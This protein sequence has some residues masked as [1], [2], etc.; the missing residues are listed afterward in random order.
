LKEKEMKRLALVLCLAAALPLAAC[1][2]TGTTSPVTGGPV[3][4]LPGAAPVCAALKS[5]KFDLVLKAYGAVTD[6]VNMAIDLKAITPGSAK[7]VA[8]ANANDKVLAALAVAEQA[9]SA[10]NATSYTAALANV[11]A[12]IAEVRTALRQ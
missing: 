1:D 8:I 6:A 5:D 9:R 10:C 7:A 2:T 12:A 11:S 3:A 4:E